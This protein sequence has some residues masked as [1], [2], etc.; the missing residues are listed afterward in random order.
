MKYTVFMEKYAENQLAL[1]WNGAGDRQAVTDACNRI[2]RELA[3]DAHLKGNPRGIF[4][5]YRD[6][7]LEYLFQVDRGDC[8]VRIFRVRRTT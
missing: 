5:T 1:L 8:M 4:R 7:P 6:D 3:N 2:E